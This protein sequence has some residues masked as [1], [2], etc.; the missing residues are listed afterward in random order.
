MGRM[1]HRCGTRHALDAAV[2]LHARGVGAVAGR[3]RE[4]SISGMFVE[5]PPELFAPRGV[6]DVEVTLA[7]PVALRTY[8]WQAMVV[9]RTAKGLGLLFD[10]LRPPAISRLLAATEA[11][12]AAAVLPGN[13]TPLRPVSTREPAP[14]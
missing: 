9:R 8:R 14:L 7:G 13:V 11:A 6:I 4:A 2:T 12:S 5:A 10:R 3:I 1:E